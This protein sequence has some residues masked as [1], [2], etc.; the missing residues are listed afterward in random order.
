MICGR[1]WK[2]VEDDYTIQQQNDL[3]SDDKANLQLDAQAKDIICSSLS[4]DIFFRFQRLNTSKE[5]WDVINNAHE[6]F[7]ARSD[8]HIQML[9][10]DPH[11]QML[12]AF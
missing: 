1:L 5:I 2:I 4:K 7:V 10:S 3:T 9:H 12:Q 11:I 8:P 6:E